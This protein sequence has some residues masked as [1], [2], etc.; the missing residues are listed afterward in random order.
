MSGVT[1]F[2]YEQMVA[3][4]GKR[5][6]ELEP[7]ESD[8]HKKIMDHCDHQ[9]PRWKYI[10]SRFGVKTKNEPGVPD[11]QISLPGGKH[12]YV[13]AKRPGQ[14]LTPAQRDWKAEAEK[15]GQPFLV[16]YD[17]TDFLHQ[18]RPYLPKP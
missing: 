15:L 18:V 2:Q 8:L 10:H 16:V 7:Q 12:V 5:L 13:E 1:R 3:R 17:I 6:P 4:T 11:F 14:K 9:W